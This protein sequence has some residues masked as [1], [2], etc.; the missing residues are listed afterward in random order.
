MGAD[1]VRV[2]ENFLIWYRDAVI[3]LFHFRLLAAYAHWRSGRFF[4]RIDTV[5]RPRV[6]LTRT[7]VTTS[8]PNPI[9]TCGSSILPMPDVDI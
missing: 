8:A 1:L 4:H 6:I 3:I 7:P 5:G 2:V 9:T